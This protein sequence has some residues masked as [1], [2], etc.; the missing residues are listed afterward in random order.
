ML[1][2]DVSNEVIVEVARGV[3]REVA[4]QEMPLFRANSEL[5]CKDPSRALEGATS[6]DQMLG[7][8]TG[9]EVTLLTPIVLS[10]VCAVMK[11]LAAEIAKSAAHEGAAAI[12]DRVKR[13]FL[14]FRTDSP[15]DNPPPLTANQ[16][17]RVRSIAFDEACRLHLS[18]DQA[19]LLADST[20]G[21]LVVAS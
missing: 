11:A 15:A 21:G 13:L 16:L 20:V 4:P 9:V 8:G 5:Y 1:S 7:F 2:E 12:D 3:V 18:Q 19:H 6:G 14:R 17:E 10:V